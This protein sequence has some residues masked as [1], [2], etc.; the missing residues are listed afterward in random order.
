[1][2]PR[3]ALLLLL[4][5]GLPGL[6]AA[7]GP[8]AA[9][10]AAGYEK[11]RA[12]IEA[13]FRGRDAPP[14]LPEGTINPF[15]RTGRLVS[16]APVAG[17]GVSPS[18]D[19]EILERVAPAI[20]V[21]GFLEVAGHHAIIINRKTYQAGDTFTAIAGDAKVEILIKRITADTY[22]FGYREAEITRRLP[23]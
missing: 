11:L 9:P 19:Q 20:P 5:L 1:M 23:R 22:T 21:R 17:S 8:A 12:Q 10:V 3:A 7:D 14:A 15:S 13:L 18:S 6:A 4:F 2:N 16:A